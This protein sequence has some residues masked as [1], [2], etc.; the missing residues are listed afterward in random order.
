MRHT[1]TK[2][3]LGLPPL[4]LKIEDEA[5]VGIYRFSCNEQ[6]TSKSL[7]YEHTSIFWDMIKEPVLQMGTDTMIPRYAFHTPLTMK[8]TSRSEWDRGFVP[9]R[10]GG[11]IW[12]TDGSKTNE[13]TGAGVYGHGMRRKFSFSLGQYTTVFQ[14]EVHAI[15]HVLMR[16]LKGAIIIGTFVYSLRQS[17]CNQGT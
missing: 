10:Q 1:A 4:H 7:W 6:W 8:L 2:V 17:S 11:L 3:L 5:Q 15:K 12:Y 16:I 13:G 14:A 9:I